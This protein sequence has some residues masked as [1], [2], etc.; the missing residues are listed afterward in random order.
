MLFN[1]IQVL[2]LLNKHSFIVKT[3]YDI[4]TNFCITLNCVIIWKILS[5]HTNEMLENS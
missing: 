5:K 1:T 4:A 3:C 2:K